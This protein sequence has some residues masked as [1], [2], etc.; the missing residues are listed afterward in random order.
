MVPR[1][2]PA[3]DP[4]SN[5]DRVPLAPALR[6]V[7]VP[8]GPLKAI[9]GSPREW[10]AASSPLPGSR[11]GSAEADGSMSFRFPAAMSGAGP[12]TESA[13]LHPDG[14][15]DYPGGRRY[16]PA[17]ASRSWA[18][19]AIVAAASVA[20]APAAAVEGVAFGVVMMRE[21]SERGPLG[22]NEQA[23]LLDYLSLG[24]SL[25]EDPSD[26]A[27]WDARELRELVADLDAAM[28]RRP[29]P[30]PAIAW[31]SPR[32]EQTGVY[33]SE[34]VSLP[35]QVTWEPLMCAS[36]HRPVSA[37]G[38][39]YRL[40]LPEGLPALWSQSL[41][42][43]PLGDHLLL[44]AGLQVALASTAERVHV[45]QGLRPLIHGVVSRPVGPGGT[46]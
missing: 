10:A 1:P 6:G 11:Y 8:R 14:S 20:P 40:E 38:P 24:R 33:V 31:W 9:L 12:A 21:F 44:P 27:P 28:A 3:P 30:A 25:A 42:G 39:V 29:L 17:A 34:P 13:R 19:S 41:L 26:L 22:L 46:R 43:E 37:T 36:L 23:A 18:A 45:D 4:A 7:H 32:P 15:I 5:P 35:E 16:D 2:S